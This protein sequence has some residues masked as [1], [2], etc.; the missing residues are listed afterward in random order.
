MLTH[1]PEI[2]IQLQSGEAAPLHILVIHAMVILLTYGPPNW[3]KNLS[4][5]V[6][7]SFWTS[8]S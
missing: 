5:I 4:R 2:K 6:S 8:G 3:N 1:G 7:V